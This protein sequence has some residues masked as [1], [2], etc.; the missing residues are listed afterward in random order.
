MKVILPKARKC[1]SILRSPLST[2]LIALTLLLT[3]CDTVL[4]YPEEESPRQRVHL[5][6]EHIPP[7]KLIEFYY[8][9][10]PESLRRGVGEPTFKTRYI[11]DIYPSGKN[12]NRVGRHV[13]VKEDPDWRD[14]E[15]DLDLPSG[16]Y[17]IWIWADHYDSSA[18]EFDDGYF[19]TSGDFSNMLVRTD[20]YVGD[21][22]MKDAL[23]G[24]FSISVDPPAPGSPA[25]SAHC[26]LRRPL[27]SFAFVSTDFKE[28]IM[29][30]ITRHNLA[31]KDGD[32]MNMGDMP[33]VDF[34]LSG[35]T[36]KFTYK[37]YHPTTFNAFLDKPVD[38]SLNISFESRLR[39][40]EGDE[41]MIGFDYFFING[42]ESTSTVAVEIFDD[43]GV[44]IASTLPVKFMVRKN[45]A[46]IVRGKFLTTQASGG[47]EIKTEF[48]G[49]F[50]VPL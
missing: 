25:L 8:N 26:M 42:E 43:D 41:I 46:T 11:F 13:I 5:F 22:E 12:E 18:S 33:P 49:D 47:V 6:I 10:Q 36:A 30:E 40:L 7:G 50:N 35:Y 1:L 2:L 37:V 21:T 4:Q 17:D 3:G 39:K 44:R 31:S 34:D 48:D 24:S 28:F 45:C 32:P 23:C 29:S 27:T 19:C 15:T 14:F 9:G 16:D 20:P 38:S